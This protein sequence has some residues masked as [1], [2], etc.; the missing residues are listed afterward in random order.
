MMDK[1]ILTIAVI[2]IVIIG[3]VSAYILSGDVDDGGDLD[4]GGHGVLLTIFGNANGDDRLDEADVEAINAMAAGTG[5]EPLVV[6]DSDGERRMLADANGDRTVDGKDA[7]TVRGILDRSAGTMLILDSY[8]NYLEVPLDPSRIVCEYYS[9]VEIM[10]LLDAMDRIVATDNGPIYQSEYYLQGADVDSI[11]SMGSHTKPDFESV[12]ERDPDVW[13]TYGDKHDSFQPMTSA[14]VVGLNLTHVDMTDVYRS[15]VIVGTLIAGYMLDNVEDAREYVGWIVGLWN[16]LHSKTSTLDDSDRPMVFYTGYGTSGSDSYLLNDGCGTIRCFLESSNL[17]TAVELAGGRNLIDGRFPVMPDTTSVSV[18][19][20]WLFEQDFEYVFVHSTKYRGNGSIDPVTPM[21]G[22]CTD[23]SSEWESTQKTISEKLLFRDLDPDNV[24][25]TAGV[26][27]NNASGGL[28]NAVTV[29]SKI[30]PDLFPDMDIQEI[31]Q[32]YI[33]IL[34]FD[35]DLD[36]HG[37]F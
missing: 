25:M 34:G 4:L 14:V 33:D 36:E 3:G 9:N 13:F 5:G 35:F 19:V 23:D 8:M 30:H 7:E 32:Q 6:S 22:Y 29:A 1:K 27:M 21:N 12:Q 26:F 17:Y 37:V 10:K 24:V 2:G 28:L 18:D 11:T 15:G 31:H 16:E 20:E